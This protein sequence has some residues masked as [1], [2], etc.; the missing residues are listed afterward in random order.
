MYYSKNY[1]VSYRTDKYACDEFESLCAGNVSIII[2]LGCSSSI[3]SKVG[4]FI[5]LYIALCMFASEPEGLA[6]KVT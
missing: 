3:K 6:V 2:M 5:F 1:K 4:D